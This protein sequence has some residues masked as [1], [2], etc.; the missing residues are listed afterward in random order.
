MNGNKKG[1]TLIELIVVIAIIGLMVSI[2]I[3]RFSDS[4]LSDTLKSSVR[5]ITGIIQ[6]LRNDAIRDHKVY[7]L[8]FDL[9]SNQYWIDTLPEKDDKKT[10]PIKKH[11]LPKGV[12]ILD[13]LF[14][15]EE[16][17]MTGEV[18]IR[19]NQKGYVQPALI[20]IA[21]EDHREFTLVISPFLGNVR[22]IKGHEEFF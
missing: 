14:P 1:Y 22:I 16:K 4:L 17:G 5:K 2:S 15:D 9:E 6:A 3:P 18:I 13:I 8:C 10:Y 12:Y 7:H 11:L 21:S 20:H 19:F